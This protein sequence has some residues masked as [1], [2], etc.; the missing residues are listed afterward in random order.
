MHSPEFK[1]RH[2]ASAVVSQMQLLIMH[3]I[4]EGYNRDRNFIAEWNEIRVVMVIRRNDERGLPPIT[5]SQIPKPSTPRRRTSA[6][7]SRRHSRTAPSSAV[8]AGGMSAMTASSS[9][10]ER[11]LLQAHRAHDLRRRERVGK[12]LSRFHV[13]NY[14]LPNFLLFLISAALLKP[15]VS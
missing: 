14:L 3:E 10:A 9:P 7:G 4:V 1:R 15:L 5:L 13:S 12:A 2:R 11:E 6:T 8:G